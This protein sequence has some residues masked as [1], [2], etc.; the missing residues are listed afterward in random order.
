MAIITPPQ[1]PPSLAEV[2]E[3]LGSIPL[4]RIPW[5]PGQGAATEA[6]VL[7]RLGGEE[8]LYELVDGILVEKPMGYYESLVATVLI[9]YLRVFLQQHDLGITL[10]EAGML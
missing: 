5:F 9:G 4:E 6:D 10:G 8:R 7:R 3:R 2:M 1:L